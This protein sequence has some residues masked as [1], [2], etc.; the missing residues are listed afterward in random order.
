[1]HLPK[2]HPTY[3]K[4]VLVLGLTVL[5]PYTGWPVHLRGTR[6]KGELKPGTSLKEATGM[7]RL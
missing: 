1:M 2:G 3:L 4:A 7:R 6:V 5:G